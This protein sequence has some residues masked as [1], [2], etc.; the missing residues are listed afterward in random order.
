MTPSL[1]FAYSAIVTMAVV[2]IYIGSQLSLRRKDT[3]DKKNEETLSKKDAY[4]YPVYGS[5]VLF[6]LY[7]LFRLFSKEYINLLLTAYFLFF[8]FFALVET[9][10][11]LISSFIPY[12]A[13]IYKNSFQYR[14]PWEK[15]ITTVDF[16]AASM[17][18]WVLS[19]LCLVWYSITKHWV[20]NNLLGL[21]FSVQGVALMNLGSYQTGCILLGGLFVY[22]IFWVFGTDVMVTVAK[23]FD[24]PIK[25]LFPKAF[26]VEKYSFSMLGLGDIVIPGIF[27]ALLL[28]Y[29]AYRWVRSKG[30]LTSGFPQPYFT[31]TLV[32]YT[33]GLVFTIFIMHSFQAAQPALLYLVPA[34]IGCSGG[35]ALLHGELNLLYHYDEEKD[36]PTQ[37]DKPK[38]EK[39]AKTK[40]AI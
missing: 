31:Y 40:K 25:L 19:L 34:C 37:K 10:T 5:G 8:G 12:L 9:L 28:R 17:V 18:S 26:F 13:N 30:K 11:P 27:I 36:L 7:V 23:S 32:A 21:T 6:G 1:F 22:D 35:L 2:P 3:D 39:A 20:A 29:D 4:M 24:A 14:F 15:E 38:K 33:L 16:N